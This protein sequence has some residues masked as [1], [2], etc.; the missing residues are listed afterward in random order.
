MQ[1][2]KNLFRNTLTL[3]V[4]ML[5]VAAMNAA[6][7]TITVTNANDSGA[8]SLRDALTQANSNAQADTINFDAAFF[9]VPRTITLTGGELPITR[10]GSPSFEIADF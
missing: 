4:L 1:T 3:T 8:G 6:A 10:D 2:I 7:A 9:N 5:T